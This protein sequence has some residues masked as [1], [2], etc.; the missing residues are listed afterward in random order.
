MCVLVCSCVGV[1][2]GWGACIKHRLI[3]E[4]GGEGGGGPGGVL[5]V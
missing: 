3:N 5:L 2:G 1:G 4:M